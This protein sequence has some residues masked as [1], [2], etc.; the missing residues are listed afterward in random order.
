LG[1]SRPAGWTDPSDIE[2]V[3]ALE[4]QWLVCSRD[5]SKLEAELSALARASCGRPVLT[6]EQ[7]RQKRR[8][9]ERT[10]EAIARERRLEAAGTFCAKRKNRGITRSREP[11]KL[12]PLEAASEIEGPRMSARAV[13]LPVPGRVRVRRAPRTNV[14][15][16]DPVLGD[17]PDFEEFGEY[18]VL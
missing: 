3:A 7:L 6:L 18:E 12:A 13:H 14:L 10:E 11:A 4:R 2:R 17:G 5:I 15:D 16:P 8:Q 1:E 9:L